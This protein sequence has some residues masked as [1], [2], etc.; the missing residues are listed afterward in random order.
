[1][2]LLD[3]INRIRD[4]H[5]LILLEHTGNPQELAERFHLCLR[6]LHYTLDELRDMGAEIGY[7]RIRKTYYYKKNFDIEITFKV[8]CLNSYEQKTI[9]GG[10]KSDLMQFY[11]I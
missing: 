9:F 7:D 6:Q 2:P 11:C 8:S 3:H 1:M 5:R 10:N 4:L